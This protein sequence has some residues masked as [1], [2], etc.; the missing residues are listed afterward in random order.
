MGIDGEHIL[1]DVQ[2]LFPRRAWIVDEHTIQPTALRSVVLEIP[3]VSDRVEVIEWP[4]GSVVIITDERQSYAQILFGEIAQ[5][6]MWVALSEQ[7]FALISKDLLKG[8]FVML[9]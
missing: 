2:F 4:R 1:R 8:L 5:G 6:D 9:E 3:D 7:C